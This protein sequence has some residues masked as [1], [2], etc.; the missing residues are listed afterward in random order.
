MA[1]GDGRVIG[2]FAPSPTGPL[3][4]GNL[5]TALAAWLSARSQGG[6]FVVR[7]ED[8]DRV[9]SR[10]DIAAR[11]LRDLQSIGVD[12]DGEQVSQSDRFALY[13]E[14]IARLESAGSVYECY[15]TR[16]E[17][18]EAV[19]APH[20]GQALYPGT[21][22]D[23][24][25]GERRR[26][27]R[28]RPPALR[29]RSDRA[30]RTVVDRLQGTH[31]STVDDVVLRRNDGVPS[32][33]LASVVDDWAQG[34]TEVVRGGDLLAVTASQMTLQQLLG[35]PTPAYLHLPLVV[36][37][38]GERL[39]KRHGAVTLDDLVARGETAAGLRSL[40]IESLGQRD[41]GRLD[42]A[43]IPRDPFVFDTGDGTTG[44]A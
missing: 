15:C 17:I 24:S 25:T 38:D 42:V 1:F 30:T 2:R 39:S 7:F 10:P 16:R 5:R 22:R 13:D 21:C 18:A 26:R 19:A 37:V 14:A 28:E 40:L 9:T 31:E 23:L 34:V 4:V 8:L 36:G 11:Q 12:C 29:L 27:R 41:D 33:N 20:G 3:H 32:Y 43:M 35:L 6:T 44:R